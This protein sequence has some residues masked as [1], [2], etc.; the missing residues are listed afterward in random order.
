[1]N[2]DIL[3]YAPIFWFHGDE[4]YFPIE[5]AAIAEHSDLYRDGVKL[6]YRRKLEDLV[7]LENNGKDSWLELADIN[8]QISKEGSNDI[9]SKRGSLRR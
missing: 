3:R 8:L 4:S 6:P 7:N 5:I 2:Q 9:Q 1:M